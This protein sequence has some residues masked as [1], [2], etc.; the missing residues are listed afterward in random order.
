MLTYI[1]TKHFSGYAL[2]MFYFKG[3]PNRIF[4]F[5]YA[6]S[7]FCL[8][9]IYLS[10]QFLLKNKLFAFLCSVFFVCSVIKFDVIFKDFL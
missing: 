6:W 2:A 3:A 1:V 10:Q 4:C 7:L 5:I 9:Q 8:L